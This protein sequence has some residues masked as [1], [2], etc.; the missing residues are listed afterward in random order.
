MKVSP[1]PVSAKM[2]AAAQVVT[3]SAASGAP[4]H[5]T[6]FHKTQWDQLTVESA[7]TVTPCHHRTFTPLRADVFFRV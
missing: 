6:G 1:M 2:A 7:G 4:V 3:R 5:W